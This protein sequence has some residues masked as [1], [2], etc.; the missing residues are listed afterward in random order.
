MQRYAGI[1]ITVRRYESNLIWDDILR[2]HILDEENK[3][4]L[5]ESLRT[6]KN[7]T[8][9]TFLENTRDHINFFV[10]RV[11]YNSEGYLSTYSLQIM[12]D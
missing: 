9:I 3:E 8:E 5:V 1:E 4:V 11:P 6:W 2:R 10:K 12:E 7:V